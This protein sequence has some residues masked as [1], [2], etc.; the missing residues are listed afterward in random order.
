MSINALKLNGLNNQNEYVSYFV[1]LAE[2]TYL[3]KIRWSNYCQCAFL[4]IY[5]DQNNPII[6]G[7]AL[8]NNLKI[9]NNK[10]PY[11]MYFLH[12]T[13]ETYEPTLDNVSKEFA[14]VYDDGE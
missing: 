14:L 12:L 7:R 11:E 2:E 1:T 8:V 6:M 3:F 4:D 5:D 9:R 13:G 10:L